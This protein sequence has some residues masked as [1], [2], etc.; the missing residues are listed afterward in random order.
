[1][2]D[3]SE[4]YYDIKFESK[5]SKEALPLSKSPRNMI[6]YLNFWNHFMELFEKSS[7]LS[8]DFSSENLWKY[9]QALNDAYITFLAFNDINGAYPSITFMSD[10][11]DTSLLLAF[12]GCTWLL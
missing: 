9:D 5:S 8:S 1:M 12:N 10:A 6:P 7:F 4:N 11:K 3:C 2:K